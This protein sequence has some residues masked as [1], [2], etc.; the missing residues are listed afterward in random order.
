MKYKALSPWAHISETEFRGICPRLTDLNGKTVGLYA[1]FKWSA[2]LFNHEIEKVIRT[3]YP[4]AKFSYFQYTR[5]TAELENDPENQS[6]FT[7]WLQ[8]V[9]TVIGSYADAGSCAMFL[10][11]NLSY[12]EKLGKPTVL[13]TKR[14]MLTAAR[15]GAA[16]RMVP[17]LRVVPCD[18]QDITVLPPGELY[19]SD[20]E[21]AAR[22]IAPAVSA[23]AGDLIEAVVRPTTEKESRCEIRSEPYADLVTE[24]TL[25]EINRLYYQRGWTSGQPIFPPT[26]KAVADMLRGT[27][28]PREHI[29]ARIPPMLGEATVEKIAVNAVMAGCLPTYMPLLIAAVQAITDPKIRFE[30]WTCSVAGWGL[31]LV[32]NGPIRR[33]LDINS[34]T[35]Y[36]TAYRKA[37]ATIT[38]ALNYMFMNIGG[39]RP[40]IEDMSH[41]GHENR[42]GVLFAEAEEVSPWEPLHTDF[43]FARED[44]AVTIFWYKQSCGL[45]GIATKTILSSLCAAGAGGGNFGSGFAY[46]IAPLAAKA[47][48]QDGWTKQHVIEYISEYARQPAANI[49]Y[50][51]L[52][53]N[54]HLPEGIIL[55]VDPG[56]S[57][58]RFLTTQGMHIIVAGSETSPY[59]VAFDA[60]SCHGGPACAKLEFPQAWDSL[61]QEF[62]Q[63]APTYIEY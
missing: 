57:V 10:A 52:V 56:C 62:T 31:C 39:I 16:A 20:E 25:E 61:V 59:G 47:L 49:N 53:G 35:N 45:S 21:V 48:A 51:L 9:D 4:K 3:R 36:L 28:L 23:I 8:G 38:K 1:H 26:E 33:V 41:T 42:L 12:M 11:Y 37:S 5:D 54:H 32:V 17:H 44:S 18:M 34:G 63:E 14:D 30:G 27:D 24:G 15:R 13:V 2:P 19:G 58:R 50:R 55:P 22:M 7:Q 46:V 40:A 43:G 6:A 29:V 60:I